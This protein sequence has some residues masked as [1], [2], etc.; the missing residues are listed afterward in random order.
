LLQ[1]DTIHGRVIKPDDKSIDKSPV[2]RTKPRTTGK[3]NTRRHRTKE[4]N[5]ME[6]KD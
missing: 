5:N 4:V 6:K 1:L 3:E 2:L